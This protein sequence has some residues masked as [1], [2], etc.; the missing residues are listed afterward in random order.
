MVSPGGTSCF[1]HDWLG[2]GP[3]CLQNCKEGTDDA[4]PNQAPR[5]DVASKAKAKQSKVLTGQDNP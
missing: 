4:P 2:P 5:I 3:V 1:G